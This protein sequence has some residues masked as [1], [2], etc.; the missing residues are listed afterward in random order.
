MP[1]APRTYA[2][3]AGYDAYMGGWSAALAPLFLDFAG[4]V[5]PTAAFEVRGVGG[6]VFRVIV[7]RQH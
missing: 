4:V 3:A 7:A 1:A 2:D 5:E 6:A